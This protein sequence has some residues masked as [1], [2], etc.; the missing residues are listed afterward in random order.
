MIFYYPSVFAADFKFMNR[1]EPFKKRNIITADT[2]PMIITTSKSDIQETTTVINEK[3]LSETVN[4]NTIANLTTIETAA[5]INIST[6]ETNNENIVNKDFKDTSTIT[7]I[8]KNTIANDSKETNITINNSNNFKNLSSVI[9][10]IE[11]SMIKSNIDKTIKNQK[12]A[13]DKSIVTDKSQTTISSA[14]ENKNITANT[15]KNLN[16]EFAEFNI[17]S[18]KQRF[19]DLKMHKRAQR[20]IDWKL[21]LPLS[22]IILVLAL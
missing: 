18:Q 6:I 15:I 12:S 21:T 16:S 19:D 20:K 13:D 11:A 17:N 8:P 3:N 4:I 14:E 5:Q 9:E 7:I 10:N 2:V 1:L 22:I